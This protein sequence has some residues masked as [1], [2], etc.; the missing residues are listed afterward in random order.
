ML[1][2]EIAEVLAEARRLKDDRDALRVE[3]IRHAVELGMKQE[4]AMKIN[5]YDFFDGYLFALGQLQKH[6]KAA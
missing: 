4:D 5:I 1:E 3:L 2:S 6:R